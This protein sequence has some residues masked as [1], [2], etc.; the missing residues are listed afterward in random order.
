MNM[1]EVLLLCLATFRITRIITKEDGPFELFFKFRR[2]LGQQAAIQDE[3]TAVRQTT[4]ELFNCPH[5]LG[6]WIAGILYLFRKP[7]KPILY[8]FTIAAGQSFFQSLE[9]K[10]T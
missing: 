10:L 1:M 8:I 9:D 7:L 4:A 6:V 2:Y 3:Y 5:C